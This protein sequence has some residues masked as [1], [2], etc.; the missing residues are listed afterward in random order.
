LI[1][2]ASRFAGGGIFG[3]IFES[4]FVLGMVLHLLG[5]FGTFCGDLFCG[6]VP[7]RSICHVQDDF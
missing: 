4:L 7:L 1:F 3:G 5:L 6:G 2:L